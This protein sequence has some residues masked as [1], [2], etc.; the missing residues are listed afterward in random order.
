LKCWVF[1]LIAQAFFL[2]TLS[3]AVASNSYLVSYFK[4]A[5]DRCEWRVYDVKKS[6][7]RTFL[8]LP[9]QPEEVYW[10]REFSKAYYIMDGNI[11][12]IEWKLNSVPQE[13]GSLPEF[14]AS[15]FFR[16]WVA[17]DTHRLRVASYH[18]LDEKDVVY[19]GDGKN[20]KGRFYKFQGR[21]IDSA[22]RPIVGTPSLVAIWELDRDSKWDLVNAIP[23]EDFA[24]DT[25]GY[26][27]LRKLEQGVSM[28]ER[29]SSRR[30]FRTGKREPYV[31]LQELNDRDPYFTAVVFFPSRFDGGYGYYGK[32]NGFGDGFYESVT[33]SKKEG[34]GYTE[35]AKISPE[36]SGH[37]D[38]EENGPYVLF[39]EA[40]WSTWFP[41]HIELKCGQLFLIKSGQ[42]LKRFSENETS[43][44]WVDDFDE[45]DVQQPTATD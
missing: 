13:M 12:S 8:K 1:L 4:K 43:M 36:C 37:V 9:K 3:A 7:D 19:T 45:R 35:L 25:L 42:L 11:Y 24:C 41:K 15:S 26:R 31:V 34:N 29:F 18:I 28:S 5:R 6:E 2:S 22:A 20:R 17:A 23:T 32:Y 14:I 40:I 38:F 27:V 21:E 30:R 10:D 33:L 39:G 44:I 16:L